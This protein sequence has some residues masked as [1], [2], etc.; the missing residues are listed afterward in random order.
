MVLFKKGRYKICFKKTYNFIDFGIGSEITDA[1]IFQV[2]NSLQSKFG[3]KIVS[4]GLKSHSGKSKVVIRCD[5]SDKYKIF[6]EFVQ[7]LSGY[8]EQIWI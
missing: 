6:A 5:K 4:V 8:I 1:S 7:K 3:F 2:L